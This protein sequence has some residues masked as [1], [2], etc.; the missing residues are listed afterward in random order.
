MIFFATFV[1]PFIYF[2]VI[3]FWK[4]D[5]FELTPAATL[6]NYREIYQ[7]IRADRGLHGGAGDGHGPADVDH[8]FPLRLHR[9]LRPPAGPTRCCSSC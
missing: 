6:A 9:P 1:A 4:V 2:F 8:R 7:Q 3:S 5:F